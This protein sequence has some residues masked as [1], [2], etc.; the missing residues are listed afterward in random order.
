MKIV[1]IIIA[2]FVKTAISQTAYLELISSSGESSNNTSYQLDWSI[3][4]SI[5][6]TYNVDNYL[7]T[8]GF[9]QNTYSTLLVKDLAKDIDLYVFPNPTSDILTIRNNTSTFFLG[10][11]SITD[12]Q[13]NVIQQK[14]ITTKEEHLDLSNYADGGYLLLVKQQN[15]LIKIFK[16]IKK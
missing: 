5:T 9:H 2:L 14:T 1:T 7:I 11:I 13:G 16:I 4:E 10:T 15:E 8:Q 6:S 3:G 12:L